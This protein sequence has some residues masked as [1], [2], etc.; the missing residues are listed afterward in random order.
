MSTD[1]ATTNGQ[2]AMVEVATGR[3]TQEVQ[4][5]MTVAKQCP[6]DQ[7][8]AIERIRQSCTRIRLAEQARYSYPKGNKRVEGPSIRLAEV[9]AQ[10]WGNL[11][12][13]IIELEQR[14]GE[15]SVMAYCWDLETNTRQTKIFTVKHWRDTREGGHALTDSRDVYEITA[16]MGARRMRACILGVIPGDVQ[17]VAMDQCRKTL[18]GDSKE[19]IVDRVRKMVE[20]FSEYGVTSRMIEM[21]LGYKLDACDEYSLVDL[22]AIFQSLRDGMSKREDWFDVETSEAVESHRD[23]A[24]KQREAANKQPKSPPEA[25]PETEEPDGPDTDVSAMHLQEYRQMIAD[26]TTI[27]DCQTASDHAN[28][29]AGMTSKDRATVIHEAAEKI[30]AIRKARGSQTQKDL[31]D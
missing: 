20:A 4:A 15:S 17:D 12:F 28:E 31:L 26:A 3:V 14:N 23:Q 27:K 30:E 13:G 7:T 1:L 6:R 2:Q 24:R 21:K 10:N 22:R 16:N 18:A 8:A 25:P 29:N 5:A 11:D 9:M 19:P